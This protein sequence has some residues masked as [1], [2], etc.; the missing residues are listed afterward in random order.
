MKG[1]QHRIGE[2]E[3]Q[4]AKKGS[5][6]VEF[7]HRL[8]IHVKKNDIKNCGGSVPAQGGVDKVED[9]NK[10]LNEGGKNSRKEVA[11][12]QYI[13]LKEKGQT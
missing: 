8:G 13:C 2:T 6:K 7:R 1:N 12:G 11:G 10:G 5:V 9:S 3:N 4:R